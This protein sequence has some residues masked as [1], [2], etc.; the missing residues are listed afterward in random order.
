MFSP[1]EGTQRG[2]VTRPRPH[3]QRSSLH[4]RLQEP[5]LAGWGNPC[6]GNS[7]TPGLG[8]VWVLTGA[9]IRSGDGMMG[10][11]RVPKRWGQA[12]VTWQDEGYQGVHGAEGQL[13]SSSDPKAAIGPP[14]A[15]LHNHQSC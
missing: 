8:W 6:L 7:G 3:S 13:G 9:C 12:P 2:E 14:R 10:L 4:H 1:S 15:S 11:Q 5:V